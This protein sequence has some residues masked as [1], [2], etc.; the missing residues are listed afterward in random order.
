MNKF[1]TIDELRSVKRRLYFKKEELE[2]DMKTNIENIKD[3]FTPSGIFHKLTGT[4]RTDTHPENGILKEESNGAPG[5]M[6][7]LAATFLELVGNSVFFKRTSYIKKFAFSYLVRLVGPTL[8]H[9]AVPVFKNMINKSG[10]TDNNSKKQT[11]S[12]P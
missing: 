8:L 3:T 4:D 2:A 9:S 6:D 7:G 11:V 10:I 12:Q 5:I 1:T